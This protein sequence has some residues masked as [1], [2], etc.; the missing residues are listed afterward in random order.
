MY[1]HL[2]IKENQIP[3]TICVSINVIQMK[4][5]KFKPTTITTWQHNNPML[6]SGLYHLVLSCAAATQFQVSRSCLVGCHSIQ[7]SCYEFTN[8]GGVLYKHHQKFIGTSEVI[9]LITWLTQRSLPSLTK[10]TMSISR[11]HSQSS[12]LECLSQESPLNLSQYFPFENYEPITICF[13][14]GPCFYTVCEDRP[15]EG[16]VGPR[17]GLMGDKSASHL[18]GETKIA[19]I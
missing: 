11:Y 13:F 16:L 3:T 4:T 10:L 8:T 9:I 6:N 12:L 1:V 18:L 19:F 5:I 17:F 15:N 2:L 14:R 7:L